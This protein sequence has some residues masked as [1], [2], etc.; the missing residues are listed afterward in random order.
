MAMIEAQNRM[1]VS[2]MTGSI[3]TYNQMTDVYGDDGLTSALRVQRLRY[4]NAA[5]GCIT[6]NNFGD[7]WADDD[8]HHA[9]RSIHRLAGKC[10][11][12]DMRVRDGQTVSVDHEGR[13]M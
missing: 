9:N 1:S 10:D 3:M 4:M 13:G 12:D 6:D 11:F 7:A 8:V 5:I 2:V